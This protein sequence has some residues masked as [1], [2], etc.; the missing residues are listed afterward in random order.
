MSSSS[1]NPAEIAREA[2]RQLATRRIAPT[3]DA[4][5]DIYNQIA[6]VVTPAAPAIEADPGA[7]KVLS[8]FAY[9]LADTPGE[10]AEIGSRLNRAVK[11]RDWDGYARMLSQLAEKH[12]RGFGAGGRSR[13]AGHGRQDRA[14]RG[15]AA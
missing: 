4:Y 8:G 10:L 3:P 1:Q 15:G 12:L 7:E 13:V 11:Q 9:R 6:G 14:R 2:F 5:R